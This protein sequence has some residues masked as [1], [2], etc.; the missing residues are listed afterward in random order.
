MNTKCIFCNT[1]TAFMLNIKE[2]ERSIQV[3]DI[4]FFNPSNRQVCK[5]PSERI[6]HPQKTLTSWAQ[7]DTSI[8]FVDKRRSHLGG[9]LENNLKR[10]E[11]LI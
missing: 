4:C 7:H 9:T 6:Q 10:P 8:A 2:S 11:T 5:S 3:L 1:W